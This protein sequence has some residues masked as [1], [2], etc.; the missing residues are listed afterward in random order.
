MFWGTYKKLAQ[1]TELHEELRR[2]LAYA[3]VQNEHHKDP[4]PHCTVAR[5][6][7]SSVK[8]ELIFPEK[9]MTAI[10]VNRIELWESKN[11]RYRSV[12]EFF[13]SK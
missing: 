5:I 3:V 9:G 2:A 11:G 8:D 4:I 1:F 10:S 6:K 13:F 7:N 12:A